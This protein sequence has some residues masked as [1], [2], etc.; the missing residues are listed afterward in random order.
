MAGLACLL[1]VLPKELITDLPVLWLLATALAAFA[2]TITTAIE[3]VLPAGPVLLMLFYVFCALVSD[4]TDFVC[5]NANSWPGALSILAISI[6]L[7]C[8]AFF[9]LR[10]ALRKSR[11]ARWSNATA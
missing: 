10:D 7:F 2:S 11:G 8:V 1:F 6:G 5:T 3:P 4:A 9:R